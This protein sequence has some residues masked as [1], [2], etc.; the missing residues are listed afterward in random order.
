MS[1]DLRL[2]AFARQ[3]RAAQTEPERAAWRM[4]RA[5]R[6]EGLKFKRQVPIGPFIADFVSFRYRLVIEI[7][8]GQHADSGHDEARDTWLRSQGFRVLRFWNHEV[9]ENA[10]G[11]ALTILRAVAET[12]D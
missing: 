2:R 6:L 5:K 12:R 8:G 1:E 3:M 4:L 9:L 10:D 11:V 7:D